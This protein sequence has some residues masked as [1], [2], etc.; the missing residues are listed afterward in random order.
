MPTGK[1]AIRQGGTLKKDEN[2][3]PLPNARPLAE[4]IVR[5]AFLEPLK[6]IA[7]SIVTLN[8]TSPVNEK[9]QYA[10]FG[11][12]VDA[13]GK[14]LIYDDQKIASAI[15][16]FSA[17]TDEI[18]AMS[19]WTPQRVI[20]LEKTRKEILANLRADNAKKPP[21]ERLSD[22]EIAAE[23]QRQYMLVF[24]PEMDP[25]GELGQLPDRF[26]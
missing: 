21:P 10:G 17:Y 16:G 12:K 19:G 3:K 1:N 24:I 6:V 8:G 11:S 25:R 5:Q 23:A 2:G 14:P 15:A 13:D 26:A 4:E 20:Q 7:T 18:T 22:E 9:G